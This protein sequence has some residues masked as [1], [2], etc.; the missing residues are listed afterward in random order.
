[1]PPVLMENV[2]DEKYAFMVLFGVHFA[3][4]RDNFRHLK[5]SI[6]SIWYIV[7]L[8]IS[9]YSALFKVTSKSM[10]NL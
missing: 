7:L 1:M 8:H 2:I 9:R 6:I 4:I 10:Y 5:I 3:S